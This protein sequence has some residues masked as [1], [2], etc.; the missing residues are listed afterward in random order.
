MK[1]CVVGRQFGP[2]IGRLLISNIFILSGFNKLNSFSATAAYMATKMPA[3]DDSFI[4]ALL[5]ATILIELG[6][7]VMFLLGI[8]ARYAAAAILAFLIPVTWIFHG[9][10]GLPTEQMRMELLQFQKNLA[11]MGGLA[12]I[13]ACGAGSMSVRDQCA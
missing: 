1:T 2:L 10:W 7:G 5:V 4:Q 3:L 6:G 13:I 11:I 8:Y 9:Y 12:Y